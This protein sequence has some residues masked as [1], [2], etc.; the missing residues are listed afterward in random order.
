MSRSNLLSIARSSLLWNSLAIALSLFAV[1]T[2]QRPQLEAIANRE[3][4]LT[5]EKLQ[6]EE[7]LERI[8][9]QLLQRMPAFGFDN[10][11]ANWEM[12]KFLQYFGDES[13]RNITGYSLVPDYF[14]IILDRD[15][16]FLTAYTFLGTSGS[17]Y[18]AK[19]KETD[20]IMARGIEQLT[21][22]VPK[23]SYY[24]VR[25]KG[26]NEILFLGDIETAQ[27]TF[28]KAADWASTYDDP[29]SQAIAENSRNTA[30]FLASR[31]SIEKT[32]VAAWGMVLE[33][34]QDERTQKIAIANI[35]QLGGKIIQ[36]EE[37]KLQVVLP[38]DP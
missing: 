29:K 37:G 28:T 23:Y 25:N 16:R 22:Q 5:P 7:E 21:P 17:I 6:Q 18:A 19:P 31:P 30:N 10:L 38:S 11:L 4:N 35:Y 3:N 12:L 1:I 24:A 9:L 36:N 34:T 13:A 2:L 26:I 14:R 20:E 27:K 15:P 32:R 8:R 33:Q